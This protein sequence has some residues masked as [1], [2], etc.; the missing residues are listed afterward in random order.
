MIGRKKEVERIQRL[1]HSDRSEFLAVTGRRRVGKTFLIDT[2]LT[3]HYCFSI[4]GIQNGNLNA[5]LVNFAVKLSEYNGTLVPQIPKNWQMAFLQL[6]HWL[7][8]LDKNQKHVIFIDELPWIDTPKSGFVQMLAHFWN[9]YLSK[10]R[11][12]LLVICGSATSW[13]VKK[14]V[15]DPGGLHNRITENIHLR[16]FN[17]VETKSFLRE[18]GLLYSAQ[19]LVRLYMTFGGIPFYLDH[20]RQGESYAIA[21]ER[22]CFAPS[23][24]LNNEYHNLFQ[25]LFNNSTVHQGI[26]AVLARH[27]YGLSHAEIVK[28]LGLSQP[29][30]SYQRAMEE[31]LISDFIVETTPVGRQK[32][33]SVFRLMDEFC[34]FYHYFIQPSKKYSPGLWQQLSE[35]QSFKTWS[36]YAFETFCYRHLDLIKQALGI[37]AVYTEVSSLRIPADDA[38]LGVQ[39]DMV[40]TRKDNVVNLCEI[41][42][43]HAPYAITKA[44]YDHLVSLKQ[45]FIRFTGTKSQVFITVI[46]NLG[47]QPNAWS[48][49]IVDAEVHFEQLLGEE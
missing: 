25:A 11:H 13:I 42:F 49:D 20:L 40:I 5:Q 17:I 36:G 19:D 39:L 31:L 27:R 4:T 28:E 10:E 41:K 30:G 35:S 7:M 32:R 48:R 45:Q 6:K 23:G 46:T 26:V 44:D 3:E 43:H 16:P 47:L 38:T 34:N 8:T 9:D 2:L 33:G 29:T 15:N 22:M 1:L 18:R 21:V 24:I 37:S 14:V 12:F